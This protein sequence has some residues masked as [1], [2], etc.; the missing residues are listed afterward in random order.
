MNLNYINTMKSTKSIF[1]LLLPFCFT[2][3]LLTSLTG[4][5]NDNNSKQTG[6]KDAATA[7]ANYI[8]AL[9]AYEPLKTKDA[10]M[11]MIYQSVMDNLT[12][13][14]NKLARGEKVAKKEITELALDA[15][16]EQAAKYGVLSTKQAQTIKT[17]REELL[18][19]L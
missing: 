19:A 10:E 18:A 3:A 16:R 8:E 13:L 17:A 7:M 12:Q 4:C 5:G 15:V 1:R 11:G 14:K 6:K 2:L 9:K